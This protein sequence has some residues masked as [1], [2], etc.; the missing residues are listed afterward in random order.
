[1]PTSGSVISFYQSFPL[2]ADK[3]FISNTISSSSYKSLSENVIGAGKFYFS[4]VNGLGDDDVR[5]SKRKGLSTSRLRGFAKGKVGPVDGSDHIGGNYAAAVNLEASFPNL[6]PE[7]Y[8]AD[9][10]LFIDAGNVWG[11][12]YD[13]TLNDSNKIRSS[14]GAA[15]SWLSPVGP[16]TFIFSTNLS[17]ANSDETEGFNFQLVTTF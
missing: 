14:T 6:L 3:N 11:V 1:M 5:L 16:M 12:D 2:Y 10:G 7:S 15:V 9:V 17:K 4:S 13:S 8:K